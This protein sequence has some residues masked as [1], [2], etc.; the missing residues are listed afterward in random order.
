[1]FRG[2]PIDGS[3]HIFCRKLKKIIPITP[4]N[5]EHRIRQ[6]ECS[7]VQL[8]PLF[9][10]KG[11]DDQI[12]SPNGRSRKTTSLNEEPIISFVLIRLSLSQLL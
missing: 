1:M 7:D 9:P 2:S 3:Q 5:L 6:I 4:F 12:A 10:S 8:K 11:A